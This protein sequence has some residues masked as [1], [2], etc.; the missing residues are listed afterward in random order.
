MHETNQRVAA[1][2][3]NIVLLLNKLKD[4][5]HAL[6]SLRSQL[7][8]SKVKQNA[9]NEEKISPSNLKTIH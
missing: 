5:H 2:E 4:N 8:E 7:D 9:L 1:L 6:E 3:K